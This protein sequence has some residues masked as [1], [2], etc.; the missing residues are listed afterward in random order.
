MSD[1]DLWKLASPE[2][3]PT[4]PVCDGINDPENNEPCACWCRCG[5]EKAFFEDTL[6]PGCAID[7]AEQICELYYEPPHLESIIP[8]GV[9]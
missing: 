6:C 8:G 5:E 1:Y 3:L 2:E 9:K 7:Q 4:C